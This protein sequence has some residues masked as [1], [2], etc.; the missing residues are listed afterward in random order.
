MHVRDGA[1]Q[2]LMGPIGTFCPK[3]KGFWWEGGARR[4]NFAS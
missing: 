2:A 3:V 1:Y 4:T